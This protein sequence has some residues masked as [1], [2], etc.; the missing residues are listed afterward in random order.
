MVGCSHSAS[1]IRFD[2]AQDLILPQVVK[3]TL[4]VVLT[5]LVTVAL[6]STVNQA[7]L[8][9]ALLSIWLALKGLTAP[10]KKQDIEFLVLRR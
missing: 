7:L 4:Y 6:K 8:S 1:C 3:F 2:E 9:R 5:D 10:G